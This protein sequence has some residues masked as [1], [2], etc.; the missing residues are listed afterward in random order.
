MALT[1]VAHYAGRALEMIESE[2]EPG[3]PIQDEL[4]DALAELSEAVAAGGSD[5]GT[6][7]AL[8]LLTARPEEAEQARQD[9]M[10]LLGLAG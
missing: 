8:R 7:A 9:A 1:T 5:A 2:V 10:R 6:R 3:R 4:K